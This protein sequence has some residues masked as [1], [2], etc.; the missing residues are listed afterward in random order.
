MLDA[1]Q[2]NTARLPAWIRATAY[3][4]HTASGALAAAPLTPRGAIVPAHALGAAAASAGHVS[5]LLEV[6]GTLRADLPVVPF[7]DDLYPSL[8]VEAARL[9]L[10]VPRGQVAAEGERGI[11]IGDRLVPLDQAGRQ[12]VD[13]YGPEATLPTYS[14]ASLL[15]GRLDPAAL[16]GRTV[17]LG[18]SAAGAG[19]RFATPF[20]SRL[21]GSEFLATAIDNILTGR[22]LRRNAA[23]RA[24]DALATLS[25]ALAAALLAGRR[26]P[27]ASLATVLS[28]VGG[29][30]L[31]IQLA[32]GAAGVW[33]AALVPSV[34][35]LLAG[36]GVEAW[37]L[38]DERRRRRR[39]ERQRANLG[40][41]F[42]P[43]VVERLAASDEPA[44]LDRTQEAV[45]MFVDIVG[46]TRLSE[47]LAPA[48]AMALLRRFHT[49]VEQAVFA[50]GG[51][52]DKFMGDG[53]MACFGVPEPY[54][55]APPPTPSTRPWRSWIALGR[56]PPGTPRVSSRHRHAPGP[57]ADGR[58]RRRHPVPIHGDRR[59]GQRR[60]PARSPDAPARHAPARLRAGHG[61]GPPTAGAGAPGPVRARCPRLPIRGRQAPL[62]AWRL[63]G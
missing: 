30:A 13:H 48:D 6:D 37:R 31:A 41:Y 42:A 27:L 29:W 24:A 17:V 25:L 1:G 19:D 63:A 43:A 45:V 49:L 15:G 35:A 47:D 8:A 3:S 16:A 26:S 58:H 2:A 46:F 22:S 4:V 57:G 51:M 59:H 39:L 40:R 55:R 7:A 23:T 32:F 11:R 54:R 21:P 52:V 28:L 56:V 14:L 62:G 10:G 34:A 18:A 9:H 44:G 33:L 38:A 61:G 5:L 36:L 50:H 53:A 60:Q 12:L 20:T